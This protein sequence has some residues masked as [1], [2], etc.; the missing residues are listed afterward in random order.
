MAVTRETLAQ[1]VAR[2]I[3]QAGISQADVARMINISP[4]ALSRALSGQRNFKSLE[5]ALIARTLRV[6][7]E[8]LLAEDEPPAVALA[9]RAQPNSNPAVEQALSRVQQILELDNLLSNLGFDSSSLVGPFTSDAPTP[10]EQGEELAQKLRDEIGIGTEDLPYDLAEL[11]ELIEKRVGVDIGFES[12]PSGLDGLSIARGNLRLAIVASGVSATRQRFTL[13]H[14]LGH[15]IAG[16]SQDLLVDENLYGRKTPDEKRANAFAAAFLMPAASMQA[17]VSRVYPSEELVARL[18]GTY[19]VSLDALAFRLHNLGLVNATTRERI[20]SMSSSR[21]ALRSGRAA[22][23]QARNDQRVP[24]NLLIRAA[25]AYV[26]GKISVRPLAGLLRVD[27][28]QLLD[29]LSPPKHDPVGGDLEADPDAL[30][31]AL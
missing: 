7:A 28:E 31:P 3:A 22:D 2:A 17:Q 16:D 9:A 8:S 5:I 10:H 21:I 19:G 27:P 11:A 23:L 4:S 25:E 26:G 14:E 18:L 20:R 6:S 24:G 1:R 29:E 13:A 30:E 15:L 12:L